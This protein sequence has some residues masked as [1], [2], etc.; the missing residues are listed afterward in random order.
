MRLEV[1]LIEAGLLTKDRAREIREEVAREV[2]EAAAW[3][4]KQPDPD[5]TTAERHVF[6]EGSLDLEYEVNTPSGEPVVM[7]DAINHALHEEMTRDERILVFGEDVAGAKGG[8]FTATHG[9]TAA[10]GPKRCYNSP[11]AE[12]TIIGTAIG[13]SAAGFKP[14]IEIQFGDYIWPAMQPLKNVAASFRY[15]SNGAWGCPMVIRVPIGGYIHGGPYHSQNIEAIFGHTPGLKIVM[16]SNAADA[17]GMLKTA[18][19]MEDPVLFLEHKWLYR[20]PAARRPEPDAN[21]LVPFGKA[22]VVQQGTDL[23]VVTYGALVH[24][25]LEVIRSVQKDGHSIEVIDLRSIVPLDMETVITSVKKTGRVLIAHEDYAFLGLGGEIAIQIMDAAFEFLDA[26]IRRLGSKFAPI[27]F[28]DP[29]ERAVLPGE[30][31]IRAAILELL[32]Y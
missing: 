10:F 7:V 32:H 3:V 23:T 16:P 21:Y 25:S 30:H 11:L 19:R 12:N 18:I 5:P 17:K 20:Q 26:P 27:P 24:K 29:L 22:R 2:D 14:V 4:E 28:A 6:Y 9:L 31:D 13:L 8:V 1:R 15:R